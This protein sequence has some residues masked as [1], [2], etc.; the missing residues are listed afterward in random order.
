MKLRLRTYY[1]EPQPPITVS[2][3]AELLFA[4]AGLL[5]TGEIETL[6]AEVNEQSKFL[7]KLTGALHDSGALSDEQ[8][9]AL[10]HPTF[11]VC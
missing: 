7:A 10:L 9:K 1:N 6:R 5:C 2:Q 8:I 3:A 11:E 4:A